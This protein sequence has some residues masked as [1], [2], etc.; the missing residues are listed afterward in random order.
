LL[1]AELLSGGQLLHASWP[2]LALYWFAPQEAHVPTVVAPLLVPA[3]QGRHRR[4]EPEP[5]CENPARHVDVGEA[6]AQTKGNT[7]V[8]TNPKLHVQSVCPTALKVVL[9]EGHREQHDAL[10]PT[11]LPESPFKEACPTSV[12]STPQGVHA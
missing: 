4:V 8:T 6:A 1:F 7:E 3:E 12:V 11:H 10:V 2:W 9:E 5:D